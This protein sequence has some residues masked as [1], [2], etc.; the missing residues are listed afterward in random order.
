MKR[1]FISI[2]QSATKTTVV[3]RSARKQMSDLIACSLNARSSLRML[4]YRLVFL[5]VHFVD[6][7]AKVNAEYYV[8]RL[9][10]SRINC[11]LQTLAASWIHLSA[12]R[13][14]SAPA[15]TAFLAQDWLNLNCSGFIEKD[16]WFPNFPDSNPLDYHVWGAMLEKYHNLRPQP[17]TIRELKVALQQIWEDLPKELINKAI[18]N[19]TKRLRTYVDIGGGHFEHKL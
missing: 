16:Q 1:T 18:K 9:L 5:F 17:K 7:K 2:H 15:H 6:E 4:W 12:R 13:R 14:T 10:S 8:G 3:G 19:F 11:R